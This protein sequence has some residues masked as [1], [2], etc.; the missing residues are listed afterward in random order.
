MGRLHDVGP[1]LCALRERVRLSPEQVA[2]GCRHLGVRVSP[3]LVRAWEGGVV[4]PTMPELVAALAVVDASPASL[5]VEVL[6]RAW[7]EALEQGPQA[8]ELL[9][10]WWRHAPLEQLLVL[11]AG[12]QEGVAAEL[13]D[14]RQR[15][16]SERLRG[17]HGP[18]AELVAVAAPEKR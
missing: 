9:L 4:L 17:E 7:R 16:L 14:A 11:L 2:S 1:A 10:G 13:M 5:F 12:R 6:R 18:L 8:V 3:E 15:E